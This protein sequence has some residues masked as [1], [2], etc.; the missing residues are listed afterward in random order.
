MRGKDAPAYPRVLDELMPS[1]CHITEQYTNNA[2]EAD[3]VVSIS[4][5]FAFVRG[6]PPATAR[7]LRRRS[8]TVPNGHGHC[9]GV[10]KIGRSAVRPRPWPP[11]LTCPNDSFLDLFVRVPSQ[12]SASAILAAPVGKWTTIKHYTE[13]QQ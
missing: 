12:F 10:L 11:Y 9:T 2:V 7:P 4:V 6:R 8:R 1:A 13:R 5:S 3:R